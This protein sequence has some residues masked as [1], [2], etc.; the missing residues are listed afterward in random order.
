MLQVL[1]VLETCGCHSEA[2]ALETLRVRR[3]NI[4]AVAADVSASASWQRHALEH[5]KEIATHALNLPEAGSDCW[6]Q[7]AASTA[8][9]TAVRAHVSPSLKGDSNTCP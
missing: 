1:Q 7:C 4:D 3:E 8:A 5:S 6:R 2:L 9:S